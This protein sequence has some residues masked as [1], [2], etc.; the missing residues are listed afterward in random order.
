MTRRRIVPPAVRDRTGERHGQLV[1]VQ[2]WLNTPPEKGNRDGRAQWLCRCDC[3]REIVQRSNHLGKRKSCGCARS[4]FNLRDLP[5]QKFNR[6]TILRRVQNSLPD[7]S[8]RTGYTQYLVRCEC[9][10]EKVMEVRNVLAGRVKSCGCL[11]REV[12][13][14]N[15][16][17]GHARRNQWYAERRAVT[18]D[19]VSSMREMQLTWNEICRTLDV[20][21]NS[22]ARSFERWRQAGYTDIRVPYERR[23]S[24]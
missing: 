20:K 11:A 5:G 16:I 15:A 21:Q 4:G 7:S 12:A 8:H 17:G 2:R 1:V 9:G 23:T 24:S 14:A 3:G 10:T 6:L 18:I 13:R 22:L 19:E